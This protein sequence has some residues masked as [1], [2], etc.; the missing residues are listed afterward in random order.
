MKKKCY[1]CNPNHH[2]W[3]LCKKHDKEL[4]DA[5]MKESETDKKSGLILRK[6][7]KPNTPHVGVGV[8]AQNHKG[9]ILAIRRAHKLA[10]GYHH[11]ALPGGGID[12]GEHFLDAAKRELKE[13]T[14][15][16]LLNPRVFCVTSDI[17]KFHWIT[18]TVIG[19]VNGGKVK[20]Q[21]D[22]TDDYVWCRPDKIPKPWYK[23]FD[24]LVVTPEWKS[25]RNIYI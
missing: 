12:V 24:N 7:Y 15:L 9:E 13:E 10:G 11:W 1:E 4:E 20:L 19:W 18:I 8:I 25:F 23:V 6:K 16:K 21:L 2:D 17:G 5:V 22:E 3:D 14:G